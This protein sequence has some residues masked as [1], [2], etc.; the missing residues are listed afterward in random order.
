MFHRVKSE[1][2]REE[3]TNQNT[4]NENTVESQAQMTNENTSSPV[5][6]SNEPVAQEETA[7]VENKAPAQEN[8]SAPVQQRSETPAP[9][10]QRPAPAS[11]PYSSAPSY[12][13][14][15][16]TPSAPA[17][18]EPSRDVSSSEERRLTIGRGITM[19]G[20]IES[21]DY[22]MV[23]GTVEA[24]LKGANTLEITETGTFYGSVDIDEANVAGRFEGELTV[25][26][27]LVVQS[28]GVI[29]GTIAYGELEIEAGA[30]IDGRLTPISAMQSVKQQDSNQAK[31]S[32]P[33]RKASSK[34]QN[35]PEAA[36]ADGSLFEKAPAVAE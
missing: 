4:S 29:T 1:S 12:Q 35:V 11:R 15:Y 32:A 30:I 33:A 14:S 25:S 13:S 8:R 10:F 24:A 5:E 21:C 34:G 19:S 20:E 28:G 3:Q 6:Q 23:E 27:R 7:P 16:S 26:G 18:S 36:N 17:T 9:G 2:S 22:L 31:A